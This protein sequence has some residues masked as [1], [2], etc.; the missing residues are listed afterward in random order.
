MNINNYSTNNSGSTLT[1]PATFLCSPQ[2][3][4][5]TQNNSVMQTLFTPARSIAAVAKKFK[6]AAVFTALL[7]LLCS[8]GAYAQPAL[9]EKVPV[10]AGKKIVIILLQNDDKTWG[11]NVFENDKPVYSLRTIPG[12]T[13]GYAN[14]YDAVSSAE[15]AQKAMQ[16]QP[17]PIAQM[18]KNEKDEL[19]RSVERSRPGTLQR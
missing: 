13:R 9:S 4:M 19:F 12:D 1:G 8:A 18:N 3:N 16:L 7:V 15:L 11:Y 17:K 10:A 5:L 6:K 14:K 2:N